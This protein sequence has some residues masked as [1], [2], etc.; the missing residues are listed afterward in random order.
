MKYAIPEVI[1][2]LNTQVA[3]F[4]TMDLSSM[5]LELQKSFTAN[6]P[7]IISS[8]R[9]AAISPAMTCYFENMVAGVA[10]A[11]TLLQQQGASKSS[12]DNAESSSQSDCTTPLDRLFGASFEPF[13]I[14]PAPPL[15]EVSAEEV[16]MIES[17]R[18]TNTR[19]PIIDLCTGMM[20]CTLVDWVAAVVESGNVTH[21]CMGLPHEC[22]RVSCA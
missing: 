16:C 21:A 6:L 19:R 3:S 13:F 15:L 20:R 4:Q 17:K 11:E 14:R 18:V 2:R 9:A 22:K 10:V 5:A 7:S 1:G 12:S 8:F